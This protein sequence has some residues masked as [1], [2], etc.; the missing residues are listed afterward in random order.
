MPSNVETITAVMLVL[1][2]LGAEMSATVRAQSPEPAPT[3][4]VPGITVT[5][6]FQPRRSAPQPLVP[7]ARDGASRHNQENGEPSRAKPHGGC[8]YEQQPL[9]LIV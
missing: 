7:D 9:E 5:P 8:Q 4:S 2:L 3:P 6:G 1:G